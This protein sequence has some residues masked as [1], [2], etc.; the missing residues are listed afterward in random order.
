LKPS[1]PAQKK[2]A[3]A[4]AT[5][6]AELPK[7]V[8]PK[9][10]GPEPKA[11][12][13]DVS[14]RASAKPASAPAK[15]RPAV[16]RSSQ[17]N[18]KRA[19]LIGVAVAGGLILSIGVVLG[20][21]LVRTIGAGRHQ[22][23]AN[24]AP[25]RPE[26][27]VPVAAAPTRDA[28]PPAVA[29]AP[30]PA[31][32][33]AAILEPEPKRPEPAPM[34]DAP[35]RP[36]PAPK[37]RELT[38]D[39]K[40]VN[41]AVDA[42][43]AFLKK[44]VDGRDFNPAGAPIAGRIRSGHEA[45]YAGLIGLTL[46]ECG[47]PPE[48]GHVV[49]LAKAVRAHKSTLDH[50]YSLALAIYF[51]ERL[52]D[53]ND[54]ALIETYAMRLVAGQ[55]A[56][57]A[58][59]YN[60]PILTATEE[61]RLV[62]YLRTNASVVP[63]AKANRPQGTEKLP[64][65]LRTSPVVLWQRGVKQ[66]GVP[67]VVGGDN[68]NTQFA[69]L[70][71]WVAKRQGVPTQPSLAFVGQHF[72]STQCGDG[73]WFY[74]VGALSGPFAGR[75]GQSSPSMTCAGLLGLAVG[76]GVNANVA[77]DADKKPPPAAGDAVITRGLRALDHHIKPHMN[78]GNQ[79]RPPTIFGGSGPDYYLYWSLERVA[80]IYDLKVVAG[81]EWYPWLSK[82]LLKQQRGDGSW[83]SIHD[84]C[85]ALLILR[86]VNVAKDLTTSLRSMNIKDLEPRPAPPPNK[87]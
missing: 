10:T 69:L 80:M 76:R 15:R 13:A 17:P 29:P 5:P 87:P 81:K 31:A 74:T 40:K 85:F 78:G 32:P 30:P 63:G 4:L 33:D 51:L 57:G 44:Y 52:G 65:R 14:A 26:E 37:K 73:G 60:C 23:E 66:T 7:K 59:T 70:G 21:Y 18:H 48:E 75:G 1:A 16:S 67:G 27:A 24:A 25:N 45:G 46:L 19:A 2:A 62:E 20:G 35:R 54:R 11:A 39:E 38:E 8:T 77:D 34:P 6:P 56:Y 3:A 53:P 79:P 58:W 28:T 72:R 43:V 22:V 68:S 55:T 83:N 82:L 49:T 64:V 41:Q 84:D 42:G 9:P 50:T 36:E 47:V 12:A 71:L 61:M 86:R